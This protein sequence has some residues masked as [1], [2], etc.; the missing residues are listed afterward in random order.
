MLDAC[1][2]A[3]AGLDTT[4]AKIVEYLPEE[5]RLILRAG[6][7]LE[8]GLRR[9]VSGAPTSIPRA[10]TPSPF[11]KASQ[12]RT[13][14][15][16]LLF[17]YPVILKEHGWMASLNVPL[18][19]DSGNFGVLEVDHTCARPETAIS[20]SPSIRISCCHTCTILGHAYVSTAGIDQALA[21]GAAVRPG[22]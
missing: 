15:I 18:R 2:R 13:T 21:S 17:R 3:R 7:R 5:D 4:H 16:A 19:T 11:R 8:G 12:S 10:A 6:R 20:W 14:A 9:A 1:P 22:R